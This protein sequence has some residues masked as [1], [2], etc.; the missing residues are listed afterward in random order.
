MGKYI[1]FILLDVLLI[2]LGMIEMK[3]N[4]STIHWYNRRRVTEKN[5]PQYAKMMGT[6]TAII[7]GS[8]V[9]TAGIVILTQNPAVEVISLAGCIIGVIPMLYGQFKYNKGIF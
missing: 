5:I 7:G 9:L 2:P 4:I 3:G 1:T 6:A 8:L